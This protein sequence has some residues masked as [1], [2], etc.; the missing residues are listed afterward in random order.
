MKQAQVPNSRNITYAT[1]VADYFWQDFL[2]FWRKYWKDVSCDIKFYQFWNTLNFGSFG[3][4]G[5]KQDLT[6]YGILDPFYSISTP[7]N[8]VLQPSI[9]MARNMSFL[10][11]LNSH[12]INNY[13]IKK[14]QNFSFF[15]TDRW[16]LP[17]PGSVHHSLE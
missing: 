5:T 13:R 3:S 8:L 1:F 7:E 17:Y 15:W 11:G 2:K 9:S 4:F 12:N 14:Q 6:C 16:T 10:D